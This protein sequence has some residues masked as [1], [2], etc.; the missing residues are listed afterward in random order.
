MP[1]RLKSIGTSKYFI[2]LTFLLVLVLISFVIFIT[3]ENNS[4]KYHLEKI[5]LN[6]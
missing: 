3:Y 5:Y 2:V 6:I 4:L 1:E